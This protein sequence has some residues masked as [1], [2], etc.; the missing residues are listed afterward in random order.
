MYLR[1]SWYALFAGMGRFPAEL[2]L[3]PHVITAHQA[4][5]RL[6][7]MAMEFSSHRSHLMG[8]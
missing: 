2:R 3:A 5:H 6:R 7:R 8:G 4:T 1:P